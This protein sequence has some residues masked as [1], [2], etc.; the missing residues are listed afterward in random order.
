MSHANDTLERCHPGTTFG[1]IFD[2]HGRVLDA[3]GFREQRLNACG[4]SLGALYPPTWMD[5]PMLYHGNQMVIQTNMV[6]FIHMILL[7][8]QKGLAMSLGE[9]VLITDKGGERVSK[10]DLDLIVN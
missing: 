5:W 9:T 2:T 10:M 7:D 4:Y 3:A 1:D 8:S 6:L